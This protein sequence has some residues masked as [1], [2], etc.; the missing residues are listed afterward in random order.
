MSSRLGKETSTSLTGAAAATWLASE[1]PRPDL[2]ILSKN[3]VIAV[4]KAN[5][6]G[7]YVN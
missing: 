5:Y 6:V 7:M 3:K 4:F 1:V 2:A